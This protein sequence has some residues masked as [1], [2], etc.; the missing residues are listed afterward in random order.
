MSSKSIR[1]EVAVE[2]RRQHLSSIARLGFAQ[3]RSS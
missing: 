2:P 3:L 1:P